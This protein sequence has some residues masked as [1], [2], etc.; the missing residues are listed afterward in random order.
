MS[1]LIKFNVVL[2]TGSVLLP[3]LSYATDITQGVV[4][5]LQSQAQNASSS[6]YSA[7]QNAPSQLIDAA[8]ASSANGSQQQQA[9]TSQQTSSGAAASG[10]T[11]SAN[12]QG[13]ETSS[14]NSATVLPQQPSLEVLDVEKDNPYTNYP[15]GAG[16]Y[17]INAHEE[18]EMLPEQSDFAA[19]ESLHDDEIKIKPFDGF[20]LGANGLYSFTKAKDKGTNGDVDINANNAGFGGAFGYSALWGKFYLGGDL[21]LN[22]LP[23]DEN[24][25][26]KTINGVT[27]EVSKIKSTYDAGF[28]LKIGGTLSR[29]I[30][31]Y[32][33]IGIDMSSFDVT[34]ESSSLF[35]SEK[36]SKTVFGLAPGIGLEYA[37]T[38]SL[39]L[40]TQFRYI[41]YQSIEDDYT[42]TTD[43]KKIDNKYDISRGVFL[44]GLEYHFN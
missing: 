6:T 11:V 27:A 33:S 36:Q 12:T 37:L 13:S 41:I 2:I 34:S 5:N 26:S 29:D 25:G 18:D 4:S 20:Y 19:D 7:V 21:F 32:G 38:R 16:N 8:T 3:S 14:A 15:N 10:Q 40:S 42:R 1:K 44:L 23:F 31:L 35:S 39:L 9:Q 22:Y 17:N 43:S 30:L 24:G 28:D